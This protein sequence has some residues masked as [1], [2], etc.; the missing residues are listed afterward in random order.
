MIFSEIAMSARHGRLF[1]GIMIA[2]FSLKETTLNAFP[3]F[4]IVTLVGAVIH[5]LDPVVSLEMGEI[6][7]FIRYDKEN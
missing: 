3:F 1:I 2:F 7:F 5:P 4:P 6:L